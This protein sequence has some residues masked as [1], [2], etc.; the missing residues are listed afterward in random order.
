[1]I[2]NSV[3]IYYLLRLGKTFMKLLR[4]N[5]KKITNTITIIIIAEL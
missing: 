5:L 4:L 2:N 1:M 3:F